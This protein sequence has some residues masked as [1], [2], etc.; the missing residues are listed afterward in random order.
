MAVREDER[1]ASCRSRSGFIS[2]VLL[3][4]LCPALG[5]AFDYPTKAVTIIVPFPAGGATD[6]QAR[7]IANGL[8]ERLGKPV[9]VENH[10]GAGGQIGAGIAAR[11]AAD[12]HTLL[13]GSSTML[14]E[15]ILRPNQAFD[16]V[17]DFAPVALI[18]EGPLILVAS[19]SLGIKTVSELLALARQRPGQLAYASFGSGTHGHLAGEMLKAAAHVDL[20]HVPY[21]GGAP[22]LVPSLAGR[23]RSVLLRPFPRGRIFGQAR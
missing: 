8:T 14:I 22:A 10:A 9:I 7:L 5:H 2:S 19:P 18:A 20:V 23:L 15:Q 12:G 11:S 13:L 17:R 1:L 4:L 3:L 6:Q 16:A 21:K